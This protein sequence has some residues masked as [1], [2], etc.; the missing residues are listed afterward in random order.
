MKIIVLNFILI[1][2]FF[3]SNSV[4]SYSTHKTSCLDEDSSSFNSSEDYGLLYNSDDLYRLTRIPTIKI[5]R[6]RYPLNKIELPVEIIYKNHTKE[7]LFKLLLEILDKS[8]LANKEELMF[9]PLET[10]MR[11]NIASAL[12]S[13][14]LIKDISQFIYT[15][16]YKCS[17]NFSFFKPKGSL[18][19]FK[20][21]SVFEAVNFLD[22][23]INTYKHN[24]LGD[25][26]SGHIH[27]DGPQNFKQHI[28]P[29]YNYIAKNENLSVKN[30]MKIID[31]AERYALSVLIK[32]LYNLWQKENNTIIKELV[33]KEF[34]E[35]YYKEWD[36]FLNLTY[37]TFHNH[38][39]IYLSTFYEEVFKLSTISYADMIRMGIAN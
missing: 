2:I 18:K 26:L 22:K 9:D 37:A 39:N 24:C 7:E 30:K 36:N 21:S 14:I 3:T 29:A 20:K 25:K 1:L 19:E 13:V 4:P 10:R 16:A 15:L 32:S 38:N 28:K 17:T 35:Y 23:F 6:R 12:V 34:Q 8:S 11:K 27:P 31:H 5:L 33:S